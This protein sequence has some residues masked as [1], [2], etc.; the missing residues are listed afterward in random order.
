MLAWV[1]VC[2]L[3]AGGVEAR[4]QTH[5]MLLRKT[6]GLLAGCVEARSQTRSM[7][8]PTWAANRTHV[9][10]YWVALPC[11][12]SAGLPPYRHRGSGWPCQNRR[13]ALSKQTP[14]CGS[15]EAPTCLCVL[16]FAACFA[17]LM[18]YVEFQRNYRSVWVRG[19]VPAVCLSMPTHPPHS[20]TRV[21]ADDLITAGTLPCTQ[22]CTIMPKQ[23]CTNFG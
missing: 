2:A 17:D 10:T 9:C 18:A 15:A 11:N 3:L 21:P 22:S 13:L 14:G 16:Y 6:L 20:K 7:L 12:S 19:R 8:L 4:S 23:G 1:S 5:S